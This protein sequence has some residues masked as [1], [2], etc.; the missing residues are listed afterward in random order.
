MGLPLR[1]AVPLFIG[2][3]ALFLAVMGYFVRAG[4]GNSEAP[5]G[6]ATPAEQGDARIAATPAPLVTDA[7]GTFTVPQTGTGPISGSSALPGNSVGGGGPAA[8]VP[9]P[10]QAD[11]ATA[12][13]RRALE[14]R[15]Q[16][17]RVAAAAAFQHFI[18]LYP[19]DPR[20]GDARANLR[21]LGS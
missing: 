11:P 4:L 8:A 18:D 16:G 9:G 12:L 10:A 14:L 20:I 1:I 6:I 7:P 15:A 5:L 2:L 21:E 3:A 13:Y 19:H 17:R